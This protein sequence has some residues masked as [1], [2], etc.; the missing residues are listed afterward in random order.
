[1]L[2][3]FNSAWLGEVVIG[4]PVPHVCTG[5]KVLTGVKAKLQARYEQDDRDRKGEQSGS[6]P[7][8]FVS[9]CCDGSD[10]G[11]AE[12]GKQRCCY[13]RDSIKGGT[14]P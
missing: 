9:A 4:P 5:I 7:T 8:E 2:K 11:D 12:P 13:V 3:T 1:L 14:V 10:R 6:R